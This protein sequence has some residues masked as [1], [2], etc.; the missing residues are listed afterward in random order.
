MI[1]GPTICLEHFVNT[2]FMFCTFVSCWSGSVG[3]I[4]LLFAELVCTGRPGRHDYLV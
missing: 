3:E 4:S 2:I 1:S